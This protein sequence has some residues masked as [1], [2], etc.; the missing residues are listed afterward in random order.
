MLPSNGPVLVL[1]VLTLISLSLGSN[2]LT[3]ADLGFKPLVL[4]TIDSLK[5]N[6]ELNPRFVFVFTHLSLVASSEDDQVL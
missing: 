5:K 6:T 4:V 3:N 2:K 1:A